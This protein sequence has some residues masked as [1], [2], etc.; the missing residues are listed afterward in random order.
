MLPTKVGR[1]LPRV[2]SLNVFDNTSEKVHAKQGNVM[3]VIVSEVHDVMELNR[4]MLES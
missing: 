4:L 1:D 2:G 3:T